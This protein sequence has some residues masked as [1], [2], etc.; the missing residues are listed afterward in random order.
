MNPTRLALLGFVAQRRGIS[1]A[2]LMYE[3]RI[4][5][6]AVLPSDLWAVLFHK[7]L[8]LE[9]AVNELFD[10]FYEWKMKLIAR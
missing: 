4:R 5:G 8:T 1:L 9:D 3:W 7:A 10:M 2:Q 6:I